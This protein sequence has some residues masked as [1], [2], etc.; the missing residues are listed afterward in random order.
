MEDI[1]YRIT[2]KES[3]RLF[4]ENAEFYEDTKTGNFQCVPEY[5]D[6]GKMGEY[7]YFVINHEKFVEHRDDGKTY[8]TEYAKENLSECALQFTMRSVAETN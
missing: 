1:T 7:C 8:L 6:D 2:I 5:N 4:C 3:F